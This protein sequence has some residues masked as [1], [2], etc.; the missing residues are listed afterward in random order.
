[1]PT[2]EIIR[3]TVGKQ[4]PLQSTDLSDSAKRGFT[5]GRYTILGAS[6][7]GSHLEVTFPLPLLAADGKTSFQTWLMW[8]QD[9]RTEGVGRRLT[10]PYCAQNDNEPW[11]D[12]ALGNTQCMTTSTTMLCLALIPGFEARSRQ[13]GFKQPESYLISKYYEYSTQ[14]GNHD[15]MTRCLQEQ[16]GIKSEW[17]Y[18]LDFNDI[19]DS[20]NAGIPLVMGL[21]Y[22][23]SGHVVIASGFDEQFVYIKDPYGIR[24]GTDNVYKYVNPGLGDLH[25]DDDPYAWQSLRYIWL[26]NGGG[27]GRMV[28][29]INLDK[30]GLK[31]A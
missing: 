14:R 25:G 30:T 24:Q 7:R 19:R 3:A 9:V 27:W 28:Y 26:C 23:P 16:F 12:G 29:S 8:K 18:D 10:F 4:S 2:L 11:I 6:D 5:A 20:I 1:M 21:E 13:N 31:K 15:A 22:V 17:R